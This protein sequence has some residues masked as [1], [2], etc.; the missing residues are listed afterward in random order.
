[1]ET[2]NK[3]KQPPPSALKT[4]KG[5]RLKGMTDVNPQWRYQAMT[6][7][8]GVCGVGWKYSVQRVWSEAG[9]DGQMCAFAEVLLYIRLKSEDMWSD[10]IPGTGGS[11]MISKEKTGLHTSDECYKMAVTDALS[12]AMKMLGVAADIYAGLWDGSKYKDATNGSKGVTG[13][14]KDK[15]EKM[16]LDQLQSIHK[17]AKAIDMTETELTTFIRWVASENNINPKSGAVANMVIPQTNFDTQFAKFSQA[18]AK[19][20]MEND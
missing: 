5:G 2:W 14:K 1:M 7:Q 19:E 10:G 3:L 4:I 15:S 12:V 18:N 6:E 16:S 20:V 17:S 9:A 13:A 8:F 11:M